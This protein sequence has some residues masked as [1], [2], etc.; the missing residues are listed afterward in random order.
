M[1]VFDKLE[2]ALHTEGQKILQQ[3]PTHVRPSFDLAKF[4]AF[5]EREEEV[6]R[7]RKTVEKRLVKGV[8]WNQLA[9]LKNKLE[10]AYAAVPEAQKLLATRKKRA[11]KLADMELKQ[12]ASDVE[13]ARHQQDFKRAEELVGDANNALIKATEDLD[14]YQKLEEKCGITGGASSH[15]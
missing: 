3:L 5:V 11:A 15:G 9:D 2:T 13:K 1:S 10:R 4:Y 14:F 8:T 6:K 7:V 12:D